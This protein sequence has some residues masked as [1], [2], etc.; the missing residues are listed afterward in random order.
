M[1]LSTGG[2]WPQA[3]RRVCPLG[4]EYHVRAG[5]RWSEATPRWLIPYF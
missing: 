2:A 1:V 3:E 4:S 5:Q